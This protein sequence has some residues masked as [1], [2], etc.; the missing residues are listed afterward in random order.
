MKLRHALTGLAAAMTPIIA[1]AGVPKNL[2]M[3]S[4]TPTADQIADQV[5]FVN[6]FYALKNYGID[7]KGD[8]VT[9][10]VSKSSDGDITTNTLTRFLNND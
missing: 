9:V 4:G 7:K 5:Y 6:H 3:P 8:T 1:F 2:P 10:L